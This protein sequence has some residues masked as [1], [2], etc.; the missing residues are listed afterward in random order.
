MI[1]GIQIDS[2]ESK[3][4]RTP[5][6]SLS[7]QDVKT[8]ELIRARV[9]ELLP[10]GKVRIMVAGQKLI[11]KTDL[12]LTPGTDLFMEVTREKETI[13]F[14]PVSSTSSLSSSLRPVRGE[15]L[16]GLL[17]RINE[18]LPNLGKSR[19][20]EI[21]EIL[22]SLALKSGSRDDQ[23]IPRLLEN[24]GLTLEKKISARVLDSPKG[25]ARSMMDQ[26][27]KQDLK[28]AVLHLLATEKG[29]SDSRPLKGISATLENLQHLNTQ[30]GESNRFLLPFPVFSGDTFDFGQ[31]FVNTGEQGKDK[32]NRVIK[33]AFLMHMTELGGV[34]ADFSIY[35]KE[36]TG[37]FM[38]EDQSICEYIRS[39]I[40]QLN[41]RLLSIGY[42]AGKIDCKVASQIALSPNALVRSLA[43]SS[44]SPGLDLVI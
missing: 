4:Q 40:P 36:I 35:K 19:V 20:P 27:I 25:A 30:T 28:A 33:I 44:D 7:L 29:D 42:K 13:S 14:K 43:G 6:K 18:Y 5:G 21:R 26:I 9:L 10:L 39:L 12:P 37:R 22:N 23:F 34:R 8:G 1:F 31:L 41:E 17:S 16:A 2:P 38:L 11:A 24:L 15:S 32:E 3:L